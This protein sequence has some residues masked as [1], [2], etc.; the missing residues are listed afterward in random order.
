VSST[1]L[2][3]S[4]SG[5]AVVVLCACAS[6]IARGQATGQEVARAAAAAPAIEPAPVQQT[7]VLE[8]APPLV[9]EL[10]QGTTPQSATPDV[11]LAPEQ[12]PL[13]A[14]IPIDDPSGH[15][16]DAFHA[17]LARAAQG[18]GQARIAFYGASHVASDMFT[19]PLR[20]RLQQRFGNAGPG[21]V[22]PAKPWRWYLHSGFELDRNRGWQD[23]RVKARA[24]RDDVYG[25]MGVALDIKNR[26]A[27]AG[28][29][30]RD[31]V[32]EGQHALYE[33]WYLKQPNGGRLRVYIDG[34]R[35]G[36]V[37]TRGD[38]VEPGYSL[39]E[40]GAG[41]HRFE[42]RAH[43][44][45]PVRLFGLSVERAMPGVVLDTL[46]IPGARARYHLHWDD[47]V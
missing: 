22:L 11:S 36:K 7:S 6:E 40:A 32:P 25:L 44:D 34:K 45:G 28:I 27:M 19:G 31:A 15:A 14:A 9:P 12:Q 24:P 3:R 21:F 2:A 26:F 47:G 10:P 18:E 30:S 37:N 39:F 43:G 23:T 16:L 46:G 29:Q 42:L 17:A 33:L 1:T 20:E 41:A 8:L 13:G 35:A 38:R 5:A 4:Q